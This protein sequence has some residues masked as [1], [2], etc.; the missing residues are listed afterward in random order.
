MNQK[1]SKNIFTYSDILHAYI[2]CRKYKRNTKSAI[3]YERNFTSKLEVLLNQIN[4]KT[5]ETGRYTCFPVLH[6]KPREIWAAPFKERIIHHLI[7][8]EIKDAFE[9]HFIDQTYSCIKYRGQLKCIYDAYKG[10]RKISH[11][12]ERDV[13]FIKL[14]VK[15]FFVSIDKDILWEIVREKI[16]ENSL[17]GWLIFR[18][19]F[20]DITINPKIKNKNYLEYV[21]KYKSLLNI[22]YKH[23]GLPIGNLTSQFFSNVYMN[24]LDQYCKH[25]LKLKYYYRYA[26]DILIFE[27]DTSKANTIINSIDKWLKDNRHMSLN[28]NKCIINKAN[29]G[30]KF[31]G[32]KM[33]YHY[34]IPSDRILYELKKSIK[35]LKRDIFNEVKLARVNSYLGM[36][37]PFNTYS[38]RTKILKDCELDFIYDNNLRRISLRKGYL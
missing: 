9:K 32:T 2:Q 7:H 33:Y 22:D 5:I 8:N 14:D 29:Y 25:S 31:L 34:I 35:N 11:N 30:V 19:I 23:Q 28:I 18:N 38:I 17:L 20:N 36:C 27:E 1:V 12:F 10:L 13:C 6:P 16:D 4:N 3:D 26:D 21:P 24:G 37:L 15:N